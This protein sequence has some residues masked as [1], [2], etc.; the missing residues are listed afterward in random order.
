MWCHSWEFGF[1]SGLWLWR[2]CSIDDCI[3]ICGRMKI[4]F[5]FINDMFAQQ[6]LDSTSD[7][8]T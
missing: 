1:I 6:V 2:V 8:F 7:I 4:I 5:M 3:L